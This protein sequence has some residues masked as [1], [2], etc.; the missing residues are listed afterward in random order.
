[1][2][3]FPNLICRQIGLKKALNIIIPTRNLSNNIQ[4]CL[5]PFKSYQLFM[6][7]NFTTSTILL[8]LETTKSAAND[9]DSNTVVRPLKK[10]RK[11]KKEAQTK[12]SIPSF[13]VTAFAT[14]KFYDLDSLKQDLL[15]SEAYEVYEFNKDLPESCFCTTPKYPIPN[16]IE[17]RHIFFFE[18]GVTV[19]WNVSSE[20]QHSILDIVKQHSDKTY[21]I[22]LINDESETMTFSRLMMQSNQSDNNDLQDD[23]ATS[24][25]F[26]RLINDHIYFR[27]F[28][29][30]NRL[31]VLEKFAYSDAIALTVKLGIL[32]KKLENF[33]DNN[34]Y[35]S[36]DLEKG[37]NS[38]T[39]SGDILKNLGYLF[40][41]RHAI[42]LNS[43]FVET[44]DFYWVNLSTFNF[45]DQNRN[46]R[47][48]S[49]P[50]FNMVKNL[51]FMH[52]RFYALKF[53]FFSESVKSRPDYI[54]YKDLLS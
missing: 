29:S 35:L 2:F 36:E 13:K 25:N 12:S 30:D 46:N 14:S 50:Y 26:T 49:A 40:K 51:D 37:L 23:K 11:I 33:I 47:S 18:D 10:T 6:F 39:K 32:E 42:N 7:K 17:P 52:I 19:F 48:L 9:I 43:N 53:V 31:Y 44:P 22:N 21:P 38:K 5:Q 15:D 24:I 27:H 45:K 34:E 20:E 16:E 28:E 3:L 1:M 41:M 4:K 54:L 8:K